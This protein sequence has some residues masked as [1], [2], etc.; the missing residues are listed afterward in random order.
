MKLFYRNFGSGQPLI[1]LHGLFGISDNWIP[2]GKLMAQKNFN[3]F[4]PDLRNH[5]QSPHSDTFNYQ[6]MLQDLTDFINDNKINNPIIL[7]H[8]MGGK[9][10]MH[11]ALEN[12]S[13]VNKLI[14]VDVSLRNYTKKTHH[15]ALVNAM[16]SIDFSIAKT[17]TDIEKQLLPEISDK[18]IRNFLMKNIKRKNKDSYE[19]KINM[20]SIN[21]NIDLIYE[22]INIESVFDGPTIFIRGGISTYISEDDYPKIKKHFPNSKIHTIENASHWVQVDAPKQFVSIIDDFLGYPHKVGYPHFS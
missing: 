6:S 12:P 21:N 1:V 4:T 5:G 18:R 8:S 20:E 7:G 22:G 17:R 11:Y 16:L 13:K 19:W 9:I 3:V 2:F 14:I 10:A 15:I